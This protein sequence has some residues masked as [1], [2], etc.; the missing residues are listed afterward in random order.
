M[1]ASHHVSYCPV[2]CAEGL[3]SGVAVERLHGECSGPMSRQIQVQPSIKRAES[4]DAP[5]VSSIL[6]EAA[7]WL[8][9]R[10][11]AMWWREEIALDRV[12]PDVDAGL[13][14]L[15]RVDGEAAGTFKF[16]LSDWSFWYDLPEGES[17]FLHRLAVRRAFAGKGVSTAMIQWAADRAR[18]LGLR[19]LR[20]DADPRR[21]SLCR[22]YE[23]QGFKRHSML[24]GAAF[25]VA[26]YQLDL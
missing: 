16:L 17:A 9:V 21:E 14:Y 23:A 1:R 2:V 20:L 6:E 7:E 24:Q 11:D 5:V 12:A 25:V 10:G 4:A 13:Y 8:R 3:P 15:A 22:F 18:A 19:Y 26:R